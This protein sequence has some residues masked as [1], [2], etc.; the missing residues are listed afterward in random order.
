MSYSTRYYLQVKELEKSKV[1][2]ELTLDEVID[3]GDKEKITTKEMI[4]KLKKIQSGDTK[5]YLTEENIIADLRETNEYA[6]YIFN[7]KGKSSSDITWDDYHEQMLDFSKKHPTWLFTLSGKGEE[8]GDLW[9]SY[10]LNGK[11]QEAPARIVYD[12][13]DLKRLV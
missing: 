2:S 8:S 12:D 6:S 10:Y 7:S 11:C 3:Q 4:E 13:F 9:K 5:K 1:V